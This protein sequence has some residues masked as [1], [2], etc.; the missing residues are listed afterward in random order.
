[1]VLSRG[2]ATDVVNAQT[3]QNEL[4]N[5]CICTVRCHHRCGGDAADREHQHRE[6][7][8]QIMP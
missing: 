3:Q 7:D 4:G 1:M 8:S 5:R 6:K 2:I